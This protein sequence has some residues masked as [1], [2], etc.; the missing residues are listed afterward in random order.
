[1]VSLVF[2]LRKCY[3]IMG[4]IMKGCSDMVIRQATYDDLAAIEGILLEAVKWL[5]SINKRGW[6]EEDI[7]WTTLAKHYNIHDFYVVEQKKKIVGTFILVDED[8]LFWPQL[9][10][11]QSLFIH[12]LC[13]CR[14]VAGTGVSKL[15]LDYFK[16]EG[17]RLGLKDVRL[18]C[19]TAKPELTSFYESHGF[20]L[21]Q[22]KEVLDHQ[23]SLYKF[24]LK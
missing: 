24:D 3:S 10:K 11:G 22:Y 2:I 23:M 6:S 20:E 9:R 5:T 1:M 15:I 19:R 17:R 12:K 8:P 21:V 7:M 18:D 4:N 13:V 14:K 16:E